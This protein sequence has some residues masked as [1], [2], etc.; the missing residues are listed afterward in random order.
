V[1]RLA[2]IACAHVDARGRGPAVGVRP[3]GGKRAA[4]GL[5]RTCGRMLGRIHLAGLL[6]A[7]RG[8]PASRG[9]LHQDG[10]IRRTV[11][12]GHVSRSSVIT[13]L[14][15]ATDG[16][17]QRTNWQYVL[18]P[19][20]HTCQ[21]ASCMHNT[22]HAP[23]SRAL[24]CMTARVCRELEGCH[25]RCGERTAPLGVA[26]PPQPG[27][28]KADAQR[29]GQPRPPHSVALPRAV[30]AGHTQSRQRQPQ[31]AQPAAQAGAP[32]SPVGP[33][34]ARRGR[35]LHAARAEARGRRAGGCAAEAGRLAARL[36]RCTQ[37][38]ANTSRQISLWHTPSWHAVTG[39]PAASPSDT[40]TQGASAT[41]ARSHPPDRVA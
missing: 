3:P 27:A 20:P 35:P 31:P 11:C 14:T 41:G 23:S 19:W 40:K 10:R 13:L 39:P 30:Q 32:R 17:H 21:A 26:L 1:L 18:D 8:R 24:G 2:C 12:G 28:R 7:V 38:P 36:P 6:P 9:R 33:P 15:H 4:A 25:R 37:R 5:Q 22:A 16:V 29:A 34:R